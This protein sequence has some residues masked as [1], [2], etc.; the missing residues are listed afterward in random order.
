MMKRL[1]EPEGIRT[2]VRLMIWGKALPPL[3][4]HIPMTN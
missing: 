2:Q 3:T 1:R 4:W